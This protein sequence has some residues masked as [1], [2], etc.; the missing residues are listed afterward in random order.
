MMNLNREERLAAM[1][2]LSADCERFWALEEVKSWSVPDLIDGFLRSTDSTMSEREILSCFAISTDRHLG[3][4]G[5]CQVY[6]YIV[7]SDP[8]SDGNHATY[9][10]WISIGAATMKDGEGVSLE[11][12]VRVAA[13]VE[14]IVERAARETGFCPETTLGYF[15]YDHP[16]KSEQ[17]QLYLLKSKEWFERLIESEDG[18]ITDHHDLQ[19]LGHVHFELGDFK[20][21]LQW[22]SKLET[23]EN[24][25]ADGCVLDRSLAETRL[26]ECQRRLADS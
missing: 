3:W 8:A 22:Y 24:Q 1:R 13:D 17:P 6:E 4:S 19:Y 21:A 25:C 2:K 23:A 10:T 20:T 5:L 11:E 14:A 15:Y 9:A 16:L 26:A 12:R 7:A 18:E